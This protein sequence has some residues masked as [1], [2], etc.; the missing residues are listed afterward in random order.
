MTDLNENDN[1]TACPR[2]D[3]CAEEHLFYYEQYLTR[4]SDHFT[5]TSLIDLH[6]NSTT[7]LRQDKTLEKHGFNPVNYL[8][9]ANNAFLMASLIDAPCII[10]TAAQDIVVNTIINGIILS[11]ARKS[12]STPQYSGNSKAISFG[13]DL[14]L[15]FSVSFLKY[16]FLVCI[17]FEMS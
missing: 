8:T 17:L 9:R 5:V 13:F 2:Q 14:L 3:G 15:G 7:Y 11:T 10:F 12:S 16:L 1:S 6:Q 4:A